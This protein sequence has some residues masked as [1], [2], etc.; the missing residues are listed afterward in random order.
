MAALRGL[1]LILIDTLPRGVRVIVQSFGGRVEKMI[2]ERAHIT[3]LVSDLLE[4]L[5][6]LSLNKFFRPDFDDVV[7]V[8]APDQGDPVAHLRL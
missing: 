4:Q 6:H 1:L 2:T 5:D 7:L 8:H 3:S